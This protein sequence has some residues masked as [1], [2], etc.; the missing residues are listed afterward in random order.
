MS[1]D[2]MVGQHRVW[3]DWARAD[4]YWAILSDPTRKGGKW[5]LD[6]FYRSGVDEIG[7][8]LRQLEARQLK[9]ARGRALDFGCGAGRLSQALAGE[10]EHVDGVDIS[11]TMVRL[12]T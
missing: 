9:V 6:E 10:F 3:E 1:D 11:E 7:F 8:V 2:S 5:D 4:P 12:A